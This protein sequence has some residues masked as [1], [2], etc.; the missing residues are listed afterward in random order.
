M[1]QSIQVNGQTISY[2]ETGDPNWG[3]NATNFAIQTSS[4][5]GK[6]GLDSGTSVDIPQTL[7]VTG[8]TTLD[9][10]L[11]V[12]GTILAANGTNTSPGIAFSGDT[13][14]GFYRISADKIGIATNGTR[15]G[16]IGTN[17]GGFIN[18]ICNF[19]NVIGTTDY[20]GTSGTIADITTVYT[21]KFSNSLLL[22]QTEIAW[23]SQSSSTI[24]G[25]G[26]TIFINN[27]SQRNFFYYTNVG[28]YIVNNTIQTFPLTLSSS[29]SI[30]IRTDWL[31]VSGSPTITIYGSSSNYNHYLRIWE[32]MK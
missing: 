28:G 24:P 13:N 11:S 21:P 7:D 26:F 8:N 27:V 23:I 2:P 15:V 17:Y 22:I 30:T 31:P 9:A 14:T 16:E 12:A 25:L 1:S 32:I 19:V 18:N 29:S 5:F 6:L 3:D 10:N 20:S 4:A